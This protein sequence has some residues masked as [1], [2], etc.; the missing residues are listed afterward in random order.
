MITGFESSRLKGA[1]NLPELEHFRK[2]PAPVK[3][4]PV[5]PG[6]TAL[7]QRGAHPM[8]CAVSANFIST[9]DVSTETVIKDFCTE[10][11]F[12]FFEFTN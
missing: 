6:S 12:F 9:T 5:P 7:L 4:E 1:F 2:T 11:L 8:H 10:D 3:V